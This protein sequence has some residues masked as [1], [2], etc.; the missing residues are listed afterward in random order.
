[1]NG[2]RAL[3]V[4]MAG[5]MLLFAGCAHL[6]GGRDDGELIE[7]ALAAWIAASKEQDVD[8]IMAG[9]SD[10]FAH[11]GY[12][13]EAADKAA[14]QEFIEYAIDAGNYDDLEVSYDADAVKIE[15]DTAEVYPI[16]WTCAPGSAEIGLTLKKEGGAW[17][18]VDASVEE[19]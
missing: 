13:Y 17:L 7:E 18:I 19:L 12:D 3:A 8:K 2:T 14:M 5:V 16:D 6:G 9:M 1:M 15:G 11:D 4:T 10:S